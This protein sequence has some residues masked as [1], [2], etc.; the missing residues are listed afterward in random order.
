MSLNKCLRP[1][2]LFGAV[3]VAT[4]L[5]AAL[6][7]SVSWAAREK[8]VGTGG[9]SE[10]EA[11]RLLAKAADLM[12]SG[13]SGRALKMYESILE[14]YPKSLSVYPSALAIGRYYLEKRDQT[15]ALGMLQR[16][17][18]LEPKVGDEPLSGDQKEWYLESLYLTGQA[19]F[20]TRR[21]AEAFP[22]LRKITREY[23]GTVWANQA[24]YYIGMCHFAQENW[25]KAI[26]ALN[27]VGAYMDP[28]SPGAEYMQAGRRFYVR[29]EDRDLPILAKQG[30]KPQVAVT[31]ANG[32]RE[33]VETMPLTED[34]TVIG[35]LPTAVGV[36]K[37][38]DGILQVVSGDTVT[39]IYNDAT[40][41]GGAINVSRTN[42][43]KVVSSGGISFTLGD[44]ETAA[45]A[46]YQ[47]EPCFVL[48]L[49]A[50]LDVSPAADVAKVTAVARYERKEENVLEQKVQ[51]GEKTYVTRDQ[52]TVTLR[53]LGTNAV[54][55]TGRFGGKFRVEG[56]REG[57][58]P[59]Q[60]DEILSCMQGDEIVVTYIDELGA[61]GPE[62]R[63]VS[64][65]LPVMGELNSKPVIAQDV[66]IDPLIR[67]KKNLVEAQ[68][69]LELARIFKSM[70]LIKGARDKVAMGLERTDQIIGMEEAVPTEMRQEAF[71]LTWELH[72]EAD[73]FDEAMATCA[74]FNKLYPDSP[75]VDAAMIGMGNA[76]LENKNY[77]LAI[78]AFEKVLGLENSS[79]KG[80]AQYRIGEAIEAEGRA[81]ADMS[82]SP[83]GKKAAQESA[84]ARAAM[85]YKACAEKYPD[86]QFAPQAIEKVVDY[87]IATKDFPQ[88]TVVL[89]Q[90]FNDHPDAPF[91]DSMYLKWTLVAYQSGD[92]ST[93]LE[94]CQRLILDYPTSPYAEKAK[95]ILP[96]IQQKSSGGKE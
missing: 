61:N 46:A 74:V 8:N 52:I 39:S 93:A 82:V 94:K 18:A 57:E 78:A 2:R 45:T 55:R 80:E 31:T 29:V 37:P 20:Q 26:E 83:D 33:Q 7:P 27:N 9:E 54:V 81:A 66:V 90:V 89:N 17:R 11:K 96:T 88:A 56:T 16:V 50:D 13:E 70:G 6:A 24:Y 19:Y 1:K 44:F 40:D 63:S 49:D 87:Y 51:N 92:I 86:S 67:T 84:A 68:A 10:L 32:D 30:R 72:I 69:Y 25:S 43:V 60:N 35:S 79:A 62:R 64:I 59:V 77:K 91:L 15:K 58:V 21:F 42:T 41:S 47:S 48:L 12:E 36:A 22:V 28:K 85:A 95:Q 34:G 75:L 73:Q 76:H 5:C 53:E 4:A 65:S 38:G 3:L 23:A 71:K 14:Q